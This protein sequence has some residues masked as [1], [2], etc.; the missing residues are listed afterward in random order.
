MSSTSLSRRTLLQG[1]GGGAVLAV[2]GKANAATPRLRDDFLWG[3]ATAGHQV[4]GGNVNSD[5]WVLEHVEPKSFAAP[6]GDACDSYHRWREDMDIV[7]QIGL[8][9]Y[10]FGVEWSRIEPAQGEYSLAALDHYRR[11]VEGCIDRGLHPLITFS[12]FTVPRWFAGLGGW[13]I[14]ANVDHFLRFCERTTGA[15]GKNYRHAL[16]FNEPNL[17]ALLSWQPGFRRAMPFFAKANAAAS[18]AI[19]SNRFS[20]TPTFDVGRAGPVQVNAHRRAV[21]VIKSAHPDLQLGLSA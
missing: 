12:H 7:K 1:A 2:A 14:D 17:G 8:N 4:E 20:A 11:M 15:L 21:E 18:A 19:G 9:T 16:T 10:R 13:E 6:S 5:S 3:A